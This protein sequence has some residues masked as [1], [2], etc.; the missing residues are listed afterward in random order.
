ME[1]LIHSNQVELTSRA[2]LAIKG[3]VETVLNRLAQYVTCVFVNFEDVNGPKG[4]IDKQCQVKLLLDTQ[5]P[6][7]VSANEGNPQTA[8]TLAFAKALAVLKKRLKRTQTVS[9][10]PKVKRMLALP[11]IPSN[12]S[13]FEERDNERA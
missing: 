3:R 7:V 5:S 6:I 4:G 9:R 11:P 1:I 12:D 8:F 13:E 10:Q 2:K